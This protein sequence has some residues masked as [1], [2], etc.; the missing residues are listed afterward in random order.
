LTETYSPAPIKRIAQIINLHH[1]DTKRG[2]SAIS[3]AKRIYDEEV[4]PPT[5][6][7][8]KAEAELAEVKVALAAAHVEIERLRTPPK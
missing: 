8:E 1:E 6:R 2:S 3:R 7:A 5:A 4:A